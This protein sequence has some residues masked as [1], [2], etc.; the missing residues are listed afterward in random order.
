[1]LLLL[2]PFLPLI[3]PL[4]LPTTKRITLM[5]NRIRH[6]YGDYVLSLTPMHVPAAHSSAGATVAYT[7]SHSPPMDG[8]FLASPPP[9]KGLKK[10]AGLE[11]LAGPLS[12]SSHPPQGVLSLS[13][14]PIHLYTF[15][16]PSSL[17]AASEDEMRGLGMG[18]RAKFIVG[19]AKLIVSKG[20]GVGVDTKGQVELDW[21]HELR[22]LAHPA[23]SISSSSSSSS[24]T[25][26]SSSLSSTMSS[27]SPSASSRLQVQS[28]LIECPGVGR[29]VADCV[30]LFSMDQCDSV[31]VDVHVRNIAIRDYEPSLSSSLSLTPTVYERIG[32]IFRSRFKQRAG[33]AH[34]VLFAAELPQFRRL[35]PQSIQGI[36]HN[37]LSLF[38]THSFFL[39]FF[40]SHTHIYV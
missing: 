35:L 24:S 23:I 28:L 38:L 19:T 7:I 3:P 34:S 40:L 17:A 27:S 25:S 8:S 10:S 18:Y 11:A 32:D 12:P 4:Y 36:T 16:S 33:W 13:L 9:K 1:L 20:G 26:S 39:S 14:P 6:K 15:P 22:A 2:T 21:L 29:K 31:P 30:A 5:L 37:T